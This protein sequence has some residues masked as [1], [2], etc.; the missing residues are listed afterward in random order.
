MGRFRW[1]RGASP[2]Y[3]TSDREVWPQRHLALVLKR[4][5]EVV[6]G[7]RRG[8]RPVQQVGQADVARDNLHV[9]DALA[10]R[11]LGQDD[12]LALIEFRVAAPSDAHPGLRAYEYVQA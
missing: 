9:L 8:E 6:E 5:H 2:P 1:Q 3:S 4:V 12:R 10:T 11:S 7:I